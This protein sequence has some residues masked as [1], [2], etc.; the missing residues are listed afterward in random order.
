MNTVSVIVPIYNVEPFIERCVRSL[1]AQTLE[2]LELVF[3]DDASTDGSL[4]VLQRV[5][6]EEV[7]CPHQIQIIQNE[8][9]LGLS[10]TR[11][12]GFLAAHGEYLGTCDSDD[13]VEPEMYERLYQAIKDSHSDIAA[14]DYFWDYE[15][16]FEPWLFRMDSDPHRCLKLSTDQHL[17]PSSFF[18]NLIRRD[19]VLLSTEKVV[20]VS[21]SEDVYAMMYAYYYAERVT[22]VPYCLYH[23]NRMNS[24]SLMAQQTR[25]AG[26]WVGQRRNIDNIVALLDPDHHPEYHLTCQWLKF[27]I[28]SKFLSAFP[29]LSAF[30]AEYKECYRDIMHYEY[31]PIDVRRKLR[32]I[33]SCYFTFWLYHQLQKYRIHS[34]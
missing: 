4:Q 30:Y 15:D 6:A 34:S 11:R 28:K 22:H 26:S 33:Y 7:D 21:Y 1:L 5:L 17:F 16:H 9:N 19:L 23:Y 27:K 8:L 10:L 13:W 18:V 3:V 2:G 14:C 25:P 29:S 12:V 24:G 32:I 20:P 31:L